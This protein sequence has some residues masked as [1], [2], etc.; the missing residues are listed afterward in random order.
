GDPAIFAMVLCQVYGDSENPGFDAAFSSKALAILK[1]PQEALLRESVCRVLVTHQH[2][3][4]S[5]HSA[6]MLPNDLFE[7]LRCG[8]PDGF[9]CGYLQGGSECANHVCGCSYGRIHQSE[10]YSQDENGTI[11]MRFSGITQLWN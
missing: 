6:L 11:E 10:V 9:L 4:E 8:G 5:V 3:K 7:I 2:E 1:Y